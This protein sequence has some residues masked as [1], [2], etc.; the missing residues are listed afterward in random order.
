MISR[1]LTQ[2]G[3]KFEVIMVPKVEGPL[4]HPLCRPPARPARGQ[5]SS[6]NAHL[7]PRDLETAQ[8]VVKVDEIATA[9]PRMQG[10]SFGPAD[11][12][13]SRAAPS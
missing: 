4:G 11:L 5:R 7:G 10:M 12:A 8:G 1:L 3:D 13:A 2:I 6:S 9:S